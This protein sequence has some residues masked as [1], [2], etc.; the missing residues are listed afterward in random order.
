MIRNV[1][2]ILFV[3]VIT[4]ATASHIYPNLMVTDTTYA[5]NLI[6]QGVLDEAK[7]IKKDITKPSF[8][9]QWGMKALGYDSETRSNAAIARPFFKVKN[10]DQCLADIGLGDAD[11]SYIKTVFEEFYAS[12]EQSLYRLISILHRHMMVALGLPTTKSLE[13]FKHIMEKTNKHGFPT[14]LNDQQFVIYARCVARGL[15]AV[16]WFKNGYR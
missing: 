12:G 4:A 16:Y 13:Q 8:M 1:K 14:L 10:A 11:I 5:L 7:D 2:A 15:Y 9:V 6:R 3:V